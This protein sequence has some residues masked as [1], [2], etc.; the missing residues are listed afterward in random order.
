[1]HK[2]AIDRI[3]QSQLENAITGYKTKTKAYE[4]QVEENKGLKIQSRALQDAVNELQS[5]LEKQSIKCQCKE[6]A[7]TGQT[8]VMCC[9]ICGLPDEDFWIKNN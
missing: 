5:Q 3:V 6:E 2:K 8:S 4:N 9:N 1:M 7:K